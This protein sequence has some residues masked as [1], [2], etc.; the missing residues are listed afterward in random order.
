[1]NIPVI[2]DIIIGLVFIYLTLS[3]LASEIQELITTIMQWRAAHLK[4]S[5]ETLIAGDP[6]LR[7][8]PLQFKKIRKLSNYLYAHPLIKNLNY[9]A[10]DP[11]EKSFRRVVGQIG[12]F[13]SSLIKNDNIFGEASSA[14]SYIPSETFATSLIE[15]L[16]IYPLVQ[17][18]SE[19]D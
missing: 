7:E 18:I 10:Q 9:Q 12:K 4:K 15:T 11:I 8:D 1:M 3:L 16:K 5:I 19:T 13:F 2:L 6:N 17:A 14:P